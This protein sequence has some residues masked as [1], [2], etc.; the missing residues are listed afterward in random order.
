MNNKDVISVMVCAYNAEHTIERTILSILQNCDTSD[1][2]FDIQIVIVNDG[3]S[4]S[5]ADIIN[6]YASTN[7]NIISVYQVNKGCASAR[8]TAL[9]Y[10]SGQYYAFCDSD[11]Y[12]ESD[13]LVSMYRYS[14]RYDA[15]IVRFRALIDNV[16]CV[17]DPNDVL[18]WNS[19]DAIREFFIHKR[20][21]AMLQMELIKS[22]VF[23]GV[24]FDTSLRYWEDQSV[25]LQ[26]LSNAKIIVRVNDA[27]YHYSVNLTGLSNGSSNAK[28]IKDS[29]KVMNSHVAFCTTPRYF[30]FKH[31][32]EKFRRTWMLSEMKNMYKQGIIEPDLEN[33]IK[34]L[35]RHNFLASTSHLKFV[36][37]SFLL[38]TI[39]FPK[40]TR[41]IIKLF[42]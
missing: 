42:F 33:S 4:D 6:K 3:S 20:I 39:L 22:S 19:K 15:D 16:C 31:A 8:E 28:K 35:Y 2:M 10:M 12:V 18:V 24:H 17:Y 9:S 14:K 27:K 41:L 11:D 38:L 23:E 7:Q 34:D 1:G 36:D 13:W 5:T 21:N 26:L 25:A 40:L 30:E 37:K 29:L 32:A